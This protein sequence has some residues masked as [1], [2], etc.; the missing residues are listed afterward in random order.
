MRDWHE[1]YIDLFSSTNTEVELLVQLKRAAYELGFEYCS[2]GLRVPLPVSK[3]RFT[4][5]SDYPENWAKYYV[6]NN[7][8][9]IDPT[10]QHGLTETL[11]LLWSADQGSSGFWEEAWHH[12]LRH[13]WCMSS[14]G[15]YGSVGLLSLVRS[16]YAITPS[17]LDEKESRMIWLTQLVHSAM[18]QQLVPRL[19]PESTKKLTVREREILKWTATGK[20]YIEIGMILSIDNGTVKFHL[21][22]TIRKLNAA[23]KTEAAIKASLL[24][25]LF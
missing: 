19:M 6:A 15:K 2:Y 7:Y 10:V 9:N 18:S 16:S 11:P 8:F 23:N 17:E 22:N 25:M 14:Q 1:T 12:G 13:G 24:G 20:T 21:G 3:P 4:L 5:L